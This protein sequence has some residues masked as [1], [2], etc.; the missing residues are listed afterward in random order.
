M[1][2]RLRVVEAGLWDTARVQ[3]APHQAPLPVGGDHTR[4]SWR[5]SA[6]LQM[7]PSGG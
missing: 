7:L 4:H 5:D 2:V 3:P 1:D 6:S